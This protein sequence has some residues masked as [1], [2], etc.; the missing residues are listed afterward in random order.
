MLIVKKW[1]SGVLN[2]LGV[3]LRLLFHDTP[4]NYNFHLMSLWSYGLLGT[5]K[6]HLVEPYNFATMFEWCWSSYTVNNAKHCTYVVR[7][8]RLMVVDITPN[9]NNNY[10]LLFF[11]L[12][13]K[14][15]FLELI[16]CL[17]VES[18]TSSFLFL[19]AKFCEKEKFK[20]WN[21]FSNFF[22]RQKWGNK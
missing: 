12:N 4:R 17:S 5:H 10:Y 7:R 1:K 11:F 2:V 6:F 14:S 3:H 9:N 22:K 15:C 13:F 18:S 20:K 16:W 8:S 21:D 19:L